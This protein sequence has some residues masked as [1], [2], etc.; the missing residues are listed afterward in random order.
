MK[1]PALFTKISWL[2]KQALQKRALE[3][4]LYLLRLVGF[5]PI[6]HCLLYVRHLLSLSYIFI[7]QNILVKFPFYNRV[8]ILVHFEVFSLA[9]IYK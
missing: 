3:N 5:K 7:K 4:I 6:F 8:A 1:V 9:S 2:A